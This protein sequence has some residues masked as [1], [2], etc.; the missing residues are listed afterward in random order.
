MKTTRRNFIN[1]AAFSSLGLAGGPIFCLDRVFADSRPSVQIPGAAAE[2]IAAVECSFYRAYRSQTAA[3]PDATTSVQID[4]GSSQPIDAVRLHPSKTHLLTGEGFPLRFRIE[5]SDDPAFSVRQLV[6]KDWSKTDFPH[7]K[8][9]I[10]QFAAAKAKGRY[11][12]LTATR[13]RPKDVPSILFTLP[14]PIVEPIRQSIQSHYLFALSKIEVMSGGVDIAL[15]RPVTVDAAY[16]N[17][18]DAQQLT[19]SLRPQGEGLVTDNPQNVTGAGEWHR[20]IHRARE[21][22]AGVQLQGG[23]FMSAIDNNIRYLLDSYSVDELLRHFRERAGLPIPASVRTPDPFEAFWVDDLPG[24][25]AGR[26]LMG[27]GNTLRWQEHAELHARMNAVV[28]GIAACRQTNGYIM[29][30][31]EDTFFVSERGSYTRSWL[32]HGLIDAGDAGNATAFEL[33]RGYYDWYDTRPY[34][35]E[36]LRGCIQGGQGMVATTRMYFTPVG[37][38]QDIQVIQRYFQENYWLDD[39]AARRVDAIW[40]YPYDRPH[41]Y[42]LTNLEAYLDLYRATGNPRYLNAVLGGWELFRENWQSAGGSFAIKELEK[43]LPKSYPLYDTLG[44]TCGSVFWILLNHRLHQLDPDEE[45]YVAEIEKSIYNVLLANQAGS[46]GIRYHTMLVG[47]KE[48]PNCMNTCCEGQGTRLIGGLPQFIYSLTDDGVYV[49]LF[50]PSTIAWQHSDTA[51]RLTMQ[52]SFPKNPDVRLSVHPAKPVQAKLR[53]RTPSWAAGAMSIAVNG[54]HAATG[55]PG[56]YTTLDRVWSPGDEISF[57]LPM[58]LKFT[59]YTGSDQIQNRE[60]FSLEYGP[61]L[62][63]AVGAADVEL[64]F[65]LVANPADLVTKLQPVSGEPLRFTVPWDLS[66]TKFMPYFEVQ[67]ESF[68][69]FPFIDAKV[70]VL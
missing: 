34:L 49:N 31:P 61:I 58:A 4:L 20:P 13:L 3:S 9:R 52:T 62:M 59:K 23:V 14:Q 54:A 33:L 70:S 32:T 27:A 56:S 35:S 45:N 37:K 36:A 63:A 51:M 60:R 16:G 41:V 22:L 46:K 5:C 53:I 39:L 66:G 43:N 24:S 12:R 8:D 47:Q 11:L 2:R 38:P 50:E 17:P 69:C 65:R 68:S 10:V 18:E 44:E 25:N 40:Q 1:T 64:I 28:E 30:Y 67:T 7:P 26:F 21:P 48:K 29:A 6:A 15:H 55:M 19:R 42:L 57:V